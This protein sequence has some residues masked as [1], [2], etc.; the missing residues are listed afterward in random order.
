MSRLLNLY[1]R[2]MSVRDIGAHLAALHGVQVSPDHQLA[3]P[4]P[5]PAL[6][7]LYIDAL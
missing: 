2:G 3:E 6:A 5:G 7:H 1:A 4:A